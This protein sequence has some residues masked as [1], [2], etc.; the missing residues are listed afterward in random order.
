M[1]KTFALFIAAALL[2]TSISVTAQNNPAV[3][4]DTAIRYRLVSMFAGD[5]KSLDILNDGKN[6]HPWLTKNGSYSGQMW[7]LTQMTPG[8]YRLT[9]EWLGTG[10]SLDIV[11]D[12]KKNKPQMA[13]SGQYS[14][15]AWK[16]T[17]LSNGYFRLT[18]SFQGVGK[19]LDVIND[20]KN[21]QII[22]SKTANVS[23]QFW[24]LVPF[25]APA[26]EVKPE[27][28]P[29]AAIS[30]DTAAYYRISSMF[31]GE[32][33]SLDVV[34][35]GKN[36]HPWLDSNGAYSGQLWKFT[37]IIPGYYRLTC[38]WL[39]SGKSLDVVNDGKNND[40]PEITNS[41][42]YSGQAWKLT[43]LPNGYFRLTTNFQGDGK[44]LD[45]I[46]DGKNNQ[47][48]LSKTDDVSGQFWKLTKL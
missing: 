48:I 2:L 44:S 9:C 46:N 18:T 7:K 13:K 26:P 28:E 33:K 11:N 34:N 30:I 1:K 15:Q 19:S 3:K 4:I 25:A 32:G 40:K 39:G 22:L 36:N 6:N 45:V 17:P 8:F 20:G 38:Q 16:F 27:P 12:A 35:D 24:K 47:I 43:P 42:P 29:I 37:P 5:D 41:G 10:K 31:S 21:N 23:G 14:G